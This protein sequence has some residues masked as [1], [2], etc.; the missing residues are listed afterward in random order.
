VRLYVHWPFCVSR[1]AYCD[2]NSRVAGGRHMRDYMRALLS[3]LDAWAR[4]LAGRQGRLA[5]VYLGGGTPSTL[6][7]EEVSAL[8]GGIA[9]RFDIDYGAE[10]TVEVNPATWTAGDYAT[11]CK[12]GVNRVSIGVQSL[13]DPLLRMLGRAHDAAEAISA[14]RDAHRGGATSVSAD[15]LLGLPGMDVKTLLRSLRAILEEGPHHLSLYALTLSERSRLARSI[16]GGEYTL[17]DEDE[18]AEQYLTACEEL[19]T[20]GFEHYEISNFCLPGHHSSHNMAYWQ[21]EEYLGVG[22]G[23]HSF[24]AGRR[25]HNTTSVLAYLRAA[26]HGRLALEGCECIDGEGAREEEIM[27]GLRTSRGVPDNIIG[28]DTR[29][30]EEL[31]D[32]GLLR[33]RDGSVSLTERGMLVSNLLITELLPA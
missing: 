11:A 6:S 12:G 13:H 4:L 20:A 28:N 19:G 31:E 5:S 21:R 1:C 29:R 15:L 32:L 24:L 7:G 9:A 22:A 3:E 17:P 16:R 18:V 27:L 14:V 10:I 30:L 33:H 23:A 8:I 26:G 2:F 25:M